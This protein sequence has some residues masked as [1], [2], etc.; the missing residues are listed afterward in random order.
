MLKRLAH[1]ARD[2]LIA[3][4]RA[5]KPA[6]PEFGD[7][8][9]QLQ[10]K[11]MYSTLARTGKPLPG[12]SEVGFKAY[13]E[14]DEDGI[15]LYIFAVIGTTNRLSLELCAGDGIESNSANLI[16]NHGWHAL[17][18]D[19]NERQVARGRSFF[20]QNPRTAVFPPL[21]VHQW[22]TRG[23]VNDFVRAR[24]F[25]GEIDLFSLDMDGI[26]YWI[27]DALEVVRPRVVVVEYQDI[28][29]PQRAL[30]V[31]YRDDFDAYGYPT[32]RGMPN[33]CG[34]SLPAFCKLAARRG[35]RLVGCNRYGY[36]AFFVRNG[37]GDREIPEVP[38]EA[39]F[40]HPKVRWGM[41][42]R[43]PLVKDMPWVEV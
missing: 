40:T 1:R 27:W 8:T 23:N 26:D 7:A 6:F 29:G 16:I 18:V 41:E 35:Y 36:N 12:V 17:L 24:G 38:V 42:E 19:G 25:E 9:A 3:P 15:L 10:L 4:L 28:I 31:P 33:F 21:F 2:F 39:C 14:T 13:S 37:L 32:T 5:E 22:V 34:A 11:H 20:E 30:T 43:F